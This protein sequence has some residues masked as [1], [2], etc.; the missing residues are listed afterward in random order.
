MSRTC[1]PLW[2]SNGQI[3]A[4]GAHRPLTPRSWASEPLRLARNVDSRRDRRR[5]RT[6]TRRSRQ[7]DPLD[8]GEAAMGVEGGREGVDEAVRRQR[9]EAVL[10]PQ[11]EDSQNARLAVDPRLDPADEAIAEVDR[12]DVVAPAP[13]D[14]RDV[15]LPEVVEAVERAEELAVPS[16]RIER[17]EERRAGRDSARR[18]AGRDLPLGLLE[19]RQLPCDE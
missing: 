16:E 17:G 1:S 3:V 14:L 12:Q 5:D 6:R 4:R 18:L 8:A 11:P 9:V 10:P 15:D 2:I 19:D 13:L 7:A